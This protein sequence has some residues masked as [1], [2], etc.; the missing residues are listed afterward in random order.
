MLAGGAVP[1]EG[2]LT[3]TQP[4]GETGVLAGGGRVALGKVTLL[5][6]N[7]PCPRCDVALLRDDARELGR[8]DQLRESSPV[9]PVLDF[10][11]P[12]EDEACPDEDIFKRFNEIGVA[13]IIGCIDSHSS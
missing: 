2:V 11:K 6:G 4:S 13:R 9:I 7:A 10:V 12:S 3:S 8:A 1:G 5:V